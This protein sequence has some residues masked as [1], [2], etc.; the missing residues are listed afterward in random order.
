MMRT[1]GYRSLGWIGLTIAAIALAAGTPGVAGAATTQAA[2]HS[3]AAPRVQTMLPNALQACQATVSAALSTAGVAAA[4]APP[5]W[6]IIGALGSGYCGAAIGQVLGRVSAS[7][8]CWLSTKP[9]WLGGG[10]ARWFVSQVTSGRYD[11]C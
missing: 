7:T 3:A 10:P 9:A 2:A 11:H 1:I 4:A 6:V 8:V 5:S